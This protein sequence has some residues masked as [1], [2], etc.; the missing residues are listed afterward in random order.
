MSITI[1]QLD[2]IEGPFT[3]RFAQYAANVAGCISIPG[4]GGGRD[5]PTIPDRPE[6][7]AWMRA[8]SGLREVWYLSWEVPSAAELERFLARVGAVGAFEWRS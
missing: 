6:Q 4:H 8:E 2:T 5:G 7:E 3:F 1:P